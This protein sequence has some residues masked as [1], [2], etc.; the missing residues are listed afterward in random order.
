MVKWLLKISII[1]KFY[2]LDTKRLSYF[3]IVQYIIIRPSL[4]LPFSWPLA[5]PWESERVVSVWALP[6]E[7]L[8]STI[9][10]SIVPPIHDALSIVKFY[11]VLFYTTPTSGSFLFTTED[12]CWTSETCIQKLKLCLPQI[13]YWFKLNNSK[14][15]YL[16]LNLVLFILPFFFIHLYAFYVYTTLYSL[17]L[18]MHMTGKLTKARDGEYVL[19]MTTPYRARIFLWRRI[20]AMSASCKKFFPW[21]VLYRRH[22]S[23]CM[24]TT[25]ITNKRVMCQGNSK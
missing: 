10:I 1:C 5:K 9:V 11:Y 19:A 15:S 17:T 8:I 7:L 14:I 2:N 22:T 24:E 16:Q 21:S 12:R 4:N 3:H 20:F 13:N 25:N 18:Y 6:P 23:T